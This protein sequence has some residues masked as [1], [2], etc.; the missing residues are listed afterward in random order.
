MTYS[1]IKGQLAKDEGS[2]DKYASST[3]VA[4]SAPIELGKLRAADGD[5]GFEAG[6]AAT[7]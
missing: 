4:C 5:E 7:A 1:W 6:S 3:I 2:H